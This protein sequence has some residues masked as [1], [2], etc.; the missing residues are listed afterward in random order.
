MPRDTAEKKQWP[1][2][3]DEE[4]SMEQLQQWMF[5]GVCEATDGC[6]IEPDGTCEHGHPSWMLHMGLI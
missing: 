2:P 3:T 1:E 4:P 6:P 5:D